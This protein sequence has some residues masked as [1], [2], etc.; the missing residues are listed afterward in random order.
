MN[1]ISVPRLLVL[2]ACGLG[3]TSASPIVKSLKIRDASTDACSSGQNG[4]FTSNG[5]TYSLACGGDFAGNDLSSASYQS[6][7]DCIAW[8]SQTNVNAGST[9]CWGVTFI[10][11]QSQCYSKSGRIASQDPGYQRN[12]I[13]VNSAKVVSTPQGAT[14]ESQC[15]AGKTLSYTSEGSTYEVFCGDDI[16]GN[17][18]AS[19]P[20]DT[21]EDCISWCSDVNNQA[22]S[23]VCYGA[24]YVGSSGYCYQKGNGIANANPYA[25]STSGIASF[26]VTAP[27]PGIADPGTICVAGQNAPYTNQQEDYTLYCGQDLYLYDT[28]ESTQ[29]DFASCIAWCST[30]NKQPDISQL[31]VGVSFVPSRTA[32]YQKNSTFIT[33]TPWKDVYVDSAILQLE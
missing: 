4:Q 3:I 26:K 31:C 16:S 24:T 29:P 9:V 25:S 22:G 13:V 5:Y 8:C 15:S 1:N 21:L 12:D 14:L 2:A 33:P 6:M 11:S 23:V 17:D 10:P 30:Y 7:D 32:C 27:A 20:K 28:I 18:G 19:G